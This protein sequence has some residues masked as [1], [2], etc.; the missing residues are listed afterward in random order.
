[1]ELWLAKFNRELA[2]DVLRPSFR[3]HLNSILSGPFDEPLLH[4]DPRAGSS[5]ELF[6]VCDACETVP[7]SRPLRLAMAAGV[8]VPLMLMT[9]RTA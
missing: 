2:D 1:M 9:R 3:D 5:A 6:T 4:L 8:V 7:S